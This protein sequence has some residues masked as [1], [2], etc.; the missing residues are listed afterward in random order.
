M[1]SRTDWHLDKKVTLAIIVALLLNAGSSV[2]WAA[3]LDQ[4]V[5][6]HAERLERLDSAVISLG[7]QQSGLVEKLARIE[8]GQ[9]FQID[10]LKELRDKVK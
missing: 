5:S 6:N 8:E 7:S 3:R 10:M 4:S 1:G 2:W 9:R